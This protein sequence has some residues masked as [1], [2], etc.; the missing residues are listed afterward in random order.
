MAKYTVSMAVDGRIDVEVEADTPDEAFD[1][2]VEAFME[3]DLKRME[4]VDSHPVNCYD[5]KGEIVKDY[6]G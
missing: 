5:E 6:N 4:V 3:V 1:K 2:A